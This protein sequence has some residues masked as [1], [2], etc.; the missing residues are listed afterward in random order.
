MGPSRVANQ[1][2]GATGREANRHCDASTPWATTTL[3]LRLVRPVQ[4][5]HVE[6]KEEA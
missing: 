1:A 3:T 5:Q 6:G 2:F 4:K